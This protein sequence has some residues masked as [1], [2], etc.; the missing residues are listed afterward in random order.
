M[1]DVSVALRFGY[2]L[3]GNPFPVAV[4]LQDI[5]AEGEACSDNVSISTID[6]FGGLVATYTWND[7]AA[8]NACWVDD[9][10]TPVEGVSI[11]PGQGLWAGASAATQAIRF[12]APEL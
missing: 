4:A 6:S 1:K 3:L 10:Y 8:D 9:S 11:A 7:W 2:T 5:V 12:P